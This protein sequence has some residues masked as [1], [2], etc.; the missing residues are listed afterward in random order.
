M[1]SAYAPQTAH[2]RTVPLLITWWVVLLPCC[3]FALLLRAFFAHLF[4][5]GPL[6]TWGA[7]LCHLMDRVRQDV[8]HQ[9]APCLSRWCPPWSTRLA[10]ASPLCLGSA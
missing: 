3:A 4:T 9:P 10:T 6:Q 7:N 8:H 2:H 1:V 5:A